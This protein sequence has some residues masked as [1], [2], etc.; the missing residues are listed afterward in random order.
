MPEPPRLVRVKVVQNADINLE[1]TGRHARRVVL[2]VSP[3]EP[4]PPLGSEM[5]LAPRM[6][7]VTG[8]LA[9]RSQAR[10]RVITAAEEWYDRMEGVYG[11]TIQET[12]AGTWTEELF[13]AVRSMRA[14]GEGSDA[15]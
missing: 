11:G 6:A 13:D 12:V 10:Q 2:E 15:W 5:V 9:D 7:D 14:K 1:P 3:T 8:F 4:F